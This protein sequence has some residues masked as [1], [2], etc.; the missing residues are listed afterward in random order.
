MA[1]GYYCVQYDCYSGL[2]AAPAYLIGSSIQ[3]QYFN[4]TPKNNYFMFN[5]SVEGVVL[6]RVLGGPYPSLGFAER[7]C[8]GEES[9]SGSASASE[10]ESTSPSESASA[11]ASESESESI[12][13]SCGEPCDECCYIINDLDELTFGGSTNITYAEF[14]EGSDRIYKVADNGSVATWTASYS[15]G[16]YYYVITMNRVVGPVI[17]EGEIYGSLGQYVFIMDIRSYGEFASLDWS[18]VVEEC[19]DNEWEP[20]GGQVDH[21]SLDVSSCDSGSGSASFSIS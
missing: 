6:R 19:P 4:A 14:P 12:P 15:S 18:G 2:I 5:E 16:G 11:S 7:Y 10:S 20:N 9:G 8:V 1:C 21:G 17:I 13:V 3:R